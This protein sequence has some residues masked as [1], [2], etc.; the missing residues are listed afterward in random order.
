MSIPSSDRRN[1]ASSSRTASGSAPSTRRRTPLAAQPGPRPQQH[2]QAL[3]R[4]VAAGEDDAVGAAAGID[5]VGNLDAVRDH[6]VVTGREGGRGEPRLLG[7]GDAQVDPVEEE[8]PQ[9]AP[10]TDARTSRRPRGTSPP[11]GPS[12]SASAAGLE[13]RRQRLVHV[14]EVEPLPRERAA[15]PPAAR[16]GSGRGSRAL[17]CPERPPSGRAGSRS[18]AAGR[19]GPD[20]GGGCG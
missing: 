15:N 11:S 7:D 3:A 14:H 2:R 8:A 18:E 9:T 16:A 12:Q 1:R 19:A 6:L 10:R 4:V 13:H 5:P 17:R 20:A